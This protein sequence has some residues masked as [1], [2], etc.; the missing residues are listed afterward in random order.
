MGF[1]S[2]EVVVVPP[3]VA[4]PRYFVQNIGGASNFFRLGLSA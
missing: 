1:I 4:L 2:E 3:W